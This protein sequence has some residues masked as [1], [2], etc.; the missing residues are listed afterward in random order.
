MQTWKISVKGYNAQVF[1]DP[2]LKK[3]YND[4]VYGYGFVIF[5]GTEDECGEFEMTLFNK[6]FK[7]LGS[8][9]WEVNDEMSDLKKRVKALADKAY[10]KFWK[11]HLATDENDPMLSPTKNGSRNWSYKEAAANAV[12]KRIWSYYLKKFCPL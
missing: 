5:T 8:K 2:V 3:K 9:P 10:L 4:V 1:Q 6:G 11:I 7:I 12:Y